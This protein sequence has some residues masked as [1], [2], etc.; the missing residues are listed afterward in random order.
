[1]AMPRPSGKA[2]KIAELVV[3]G[4]RDRT[5]GKSRRSVAPRGSLSKVEKKQTANIENKKGLTV[6]PKHS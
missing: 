1:M 4:L 3:P 2:L 5:K 6:F